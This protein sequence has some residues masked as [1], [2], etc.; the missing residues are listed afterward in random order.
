MVQSELFPI[1]ILDPP[2]PTTLS[3]P[4]LVKSCFPLLLRDFHERTNLSRQR[5]SLCIAPVEHTLHSLIYIQPAAASKVLDSNFQSPSV[6]TSVFPGRPH[7]SLLSL[8]STRISHNI[9]TLPENLTLSPSYFVTNASSLDQKT[10]LRRHCHLSTSALLPLIRSSVK[11]FLRPR[12]LTNLCQRRSNLYFIYKIMSGGSGSGPLQPTW[13][14]FVNNSMDGLMLFEACLSGKLHHV[15][16]RPHDRERGNL[17]KSGSVFIY[18]E[19][20]SGI[21]RWTD[22]VAWSPSRILGNFL[23]YRE[24]EK[25]FPPGEKKRA[26]KRK[27]SQEP[28]ARRGSEENEQPEYTGLPPTPPSPANP[29]ESKPEQPGAQDNDKEME[30]QLIGSLVDSYG[31]RPNGLVKK[32]MSISLNGVS[33]HLVSYYTVEDVKQ[34]RLNRPLSDSRLTGLTVRPELF[35]KQNFRAPVEETEHY[36][37]DAVGH[38]YPHMVY[39]PMVA[40]AYAMRP[41]AYGAS[42]YPMYGM[43]AS[44]GPMYSGLPATAWPTTPQST[45]TAGYGAHAYS[46]PGYDYYNRNGTSTPQQSSNSVKQEDSNPSSSSY[47]SYPNSYPSVNRTGPTNSAYPPIQSQYQPP[48]RHNS[49]SYGAPSSTTPTSHAGNPAQQVY[50]SS[51]PSHQPQQYSSQS[52][53]ASQSAHQTGSPHSSIKSPVPGS[54]H[55]MSS[56]PPRSSLP[57]A[58]GGYAGS[59]SSQNGGL[60]AGYS[61]N[62]SHTSTYG[63]TNYGQSGYGSSAQAFRSSTEGGAG[64]P[65]SGYT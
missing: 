53:S 57:S 33:H 61:S 44:T 38:A 14:G 11:A 39:S 52:Y 19:N 1:S 16:R 30:R 13:S 34:R 21:K 45:V 18:E 64:V 8:N 29:T 63:N 5:T 51:T 37:V 3:L 47:M 31:F 54:S 59:Y 28:D 12:R 49:S 40:G 60:S 6:Y 35:M 48:M 41:G 2:L 4:K 10:H 42:G 46:A 17:I 24:L 65:A 55:S 50:S 20:A 22:G 36:A 27:R 43:G 56:L 9:H 15:P 26:M 7:P 32:T 62:P 25:P 23:I 58:M